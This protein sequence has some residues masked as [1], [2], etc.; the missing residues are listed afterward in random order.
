MYRDAG[1]SYFSSTPASSRSSSSE[2]PRSVNSSFTAG[3][4][5]S[6]IRSRS[7][8]T[9]SIAVGGVRGRADRA[10]RV[11]GLPPARH[12]LR[13]A[14]QVEHLPQHRELL[15]ETLGILGPVRLVAG[16]HVG[17]SDGTPLV[18]VHV[19]DLLGPA[20]DEQTRH[21]V[22]VPVDGADR[23]AAGRTQLL[24]PREE[25]P[26][27]QAGDVEQQR[28][29]HATASARASSTSNRKRRASQS[30]RIS[31]PPQGPHA[32]LGRRAPTRGPGRPWRVPRRGACRAVS[33]SVMAS[34]RISTDLAGSASSRPA[35]IRACTALWTE[36]VEASRSR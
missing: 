15:G 24:P 29:R 19:H 12:R 21:H 13:H 9:I 2:T 1:T 22:E 16:V 30:V 8:L 25:R 4:R 28:V 18:V 14:G 20:R 34:R 17:P 31:R 23:P 27:H 33:Y 32:D 7:P 5:T 11:L 35:T 10:D 26:V 36:A 6:W 3:S